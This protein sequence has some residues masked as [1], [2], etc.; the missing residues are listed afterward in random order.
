M[1]Q[2]EYGNLEKWYNNYFQEFCVHDEKIS[3]NIQLK[4]EHTFRVCSETEKISTSLNLKEKDVLIAKTAALFHDVGRFEQYAKYCTF[5]DL[6]SVNHAELAIDILERY[7]VLENLREHE[8]KL[9]EKS[10]LLHNKKQLP[11]DLDEETL[12]FARILRD[13]DKLDIWKIV[14][15]H[16]SGSN[17]SGNGAI[18]FGLPDTPGISDGA[19]NSLLLEQLVD[20]SDIRNVNDFKLLLLGWI[21]D[22]NFP[23]SVQEVLNRKYIEQLQQFLPNNEKPKTIISVIKKYAD[24]KMTEERT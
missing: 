13:A 1:T 16:Y 20:V 10:I 11:S 5:L 21:Y 3:E 15:E 9:I 4:R 22:L 17:H 18:E 6:K 12:L 24:S 14:L 8:K 19:Y 7:H 2:T 23:H